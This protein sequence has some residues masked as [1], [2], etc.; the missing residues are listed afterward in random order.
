MKIDISSI[1]R[2]RGL[3]FNLEVREKINFDKI[4][5][6]EIEE[7]LG[8]VLI[9]NTG[10]SI[11]VKGIINTVAKLKCSRCLEDF[12]LPIKVNIEEEFKEGISKNEGNFYE[13]DFIDLKDIFY[14]NIILSL[15][16]KSLCKENCLGLCDVCGKDLN[17]EKCNCK[18]EETNERFAPLK[19]LIGGEK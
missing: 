10:E 7:I 13:G 3:S 9:T 15:P 1:K 8:D 16:F 11:F 6:E 5:D 2:E 17:F 4:Q 19:N 18:K 14:Q 12:S